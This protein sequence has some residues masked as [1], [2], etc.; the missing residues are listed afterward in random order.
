M[1][2]QVINTLQR[3]CNIGTLNLNHRK[4]F[5]GLLKNIFVQTVTNLSVFQ[6]KFK[7]K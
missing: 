6:L 2:P 4:I 1:R 3:Q 7:G 5:Y